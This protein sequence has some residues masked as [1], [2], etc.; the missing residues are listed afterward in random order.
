MWRT[1]NRQNTCQHLRLALQKE[2]KSLRFSAMPVECWSDVYSKVSVGLGVGMQERN[3]CLMYCNCFQPLLE[4]LH[5]FALEYLV[6]AISAR[7]SPQ[8][9]C[10][11]T[12]LDIH[13]HA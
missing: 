4:H 2:K 5:H 6:T 12:F 3:R 13:S 1:A 11:S 8:Y 7:L 10:H 9:P